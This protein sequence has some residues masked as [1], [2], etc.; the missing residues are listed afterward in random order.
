MKVK[1]PFVSQ[2]KVTGTDANN[3]STQADKFPKATIVEEGGWEDG[4]LTDKQKTAGLKYLVSKKVK[5]SWTYQPKTKL[6][7]IMKGGAKARPGF[8]IGLTC[9]GAYLP[10][11]K[12]DFSMFVKSAR[13]LWQ[14]D[15]AKI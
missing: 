1:L 9:S 7:V 5:V 14:F 13:R 11:S 12:I 15:R 6:K 8:A 3:P 2:P 4:E 10:Y